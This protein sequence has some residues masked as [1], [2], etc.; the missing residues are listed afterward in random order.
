MLKNGP[1]KALHPCGTESWNRPEGRI[2]EGGTDNQKH[3]DTL[4]CPACVCPVAEQVFHVPPEERKYKG[5][6]RF[7]EGEQAKICLDIMRKTGAHLELSL[8]KDQGLSI[9]VSGKPEAV[10]KAR[11][12]IVARLQTQVRAS[13]SFCL[14]LCSSPR[15]ANALRPLGPCACKPKRYD[16][17]SFAIRFQSPQLAIWH[18]NEA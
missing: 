13:N 16:Q 10:T 4:L 18:G 3:T 2:A 1:D 9:V 15:L 5:M 17:F 6:N 8:A 12:Q 14:H 7:A 11:K